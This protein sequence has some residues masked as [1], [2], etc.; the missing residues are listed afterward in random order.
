MGAA[1]RDTG[2][3]AD[4]RRT[5]KLS[6]NARKLKVAPKPNERPFRLEPVIGAA[7]ELDRYWD[8]VRLGIEE[9][10]SKSHIQ[11]LHCYRGKP[12]DWRCDDRSHCYYTYKPED[13]YMAL[14]MNRASLYMTWL[15][16]RLTGF[17]ICQQ[18]ADVSVNQPP[19]LLAWI[20]YS[21]DP[22]TVKLYFLE[23]ENLARSLNLKEIRMYSTRKGWLKHK[24]G[25]NWEILTSHG[26]V[27]EADFWGLRIA[28]EI[29]LRRVL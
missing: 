12:R 1:A 29:C 10:I 8:F 26:W 22:E 17:G 3:N 19:H 7:H 28:P 23:L 16:G 15:R 18:I 13:V 4:K 11:G 24:P 20:G 27:K 5:G 25:P 9:V 21:K 14:R 2:G 6:Q